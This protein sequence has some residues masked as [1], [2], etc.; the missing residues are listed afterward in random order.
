[1]GVWALSLLISSPPLIGWN[2]WP[3]E[4]THDT[5]CQLTTNRGY[6]IYSSLGSFFIPLG[7]LI[8]PTFALNFLNFCLT[9]AVI[10]TIVYIEIYIA[11]RRRLRERAKASKMNAMAIRSTGTAQNNGDNNHHAVRDKD[12]ESISSEHNH[13][14]SGAGNSDNSGGSR[15]KKKKRK[16]D[17]KKMTK[18]SVKDKKEK[19]NL[20][21]PLST[22]DSVT[23][24]PDAHDNNQ[25]D[26]EGGKHTV[27]ELDKPNFHKKENSIPIIPKKT[28]TVYQFIEEKQKISLSKERRAARTLGIIMGVFCVCWLPFFLMYVIL[29]FCS[30]CCP[31]EKIVNF[32]TWLG[33][34]NSALNPIIY[35]IFNL[36]YRRAF[37]KLLGIKP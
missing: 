8:F 10:M 17:K 23:D 1:M 16:K 27:I 5:P 7:E 33:Y 26:V 24:V 34:I 15:E 18:D 32:I 37:K 29:P 2:D 20:T 22:E 14:D 25:N 3:D 28:G 12:R 9:F 35:T 4:F 6:V 19:Q 36:E 21:L 13:A 31:S 11:T 30:S